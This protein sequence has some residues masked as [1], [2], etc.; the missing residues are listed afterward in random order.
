MN[1]DAEDARE[2]EHALFSCQAEW[3]ASLSLA[4]MLLTGAKSTWLGAQ[5]SVECASHTVDVYHLPTTFTTDQQNTLLQ[6][7]EAQ[8]AQN[9][10]TPRPKP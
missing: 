10:S 3:R 6:P 4:D 9:I 7:S 8:F 2:P 5:L 1:L